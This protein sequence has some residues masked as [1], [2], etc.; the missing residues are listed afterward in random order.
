[1]DKFFLALGQIYDD[2]DRIALAESRLRLL[3]QGKQSAEIYCSEFRRWAADT[4]WNDAALRSQFCHDLSEGLKDAFASHE[5]PTSLDSAMS[6]AVRIDRRLR[7]RGEISP[8]CHT[9]SRDSAAVSFCAQ[10]SQSLSAPSEQVSMQLGL[11]ASENRR[12]S[13]QGRVC[14]C[15]GGINHLANVCP[16]RRFRQFS[17]SNKETKRKKSFKNVPS[18]TIGRVEAEIEG[19]PFACSSR[20]V[21]P[22]RVALESK[23]IFCEIFCG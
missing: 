16:S 21:L 4:G 18:V 15:C 5:R 11:I 1:M 22:A 10:G 14:F 19:F 6:Q 12:F 3:C 2:P 20:F 9:Q 13:P 23:S 17:G 7:E 8:F